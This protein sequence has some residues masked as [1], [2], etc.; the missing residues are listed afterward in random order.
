MTQVWTNWAGNQQARPQAAYVPRDV[1]ELRSVVERATASG[2]RVKAV[3]AGHSFTGV[4]VT[5]GVSVSLDHLTGIESVTRCDDGTSLVTVGAGTRL[6]DLGPALWERGLAMTNL[7]DIDAQSVAGALSTGTHGT[8][9]RFGGLASQVVGARIVLSDGDEVEATG[10][11]LEAARLGLGA[12]GVL[13][14]VTLRCEPAF[15]LRAV[16]APG[17]L[18][19][20]LE[21]FA[22]T[23]AALDHYEFYWFPHTDRVLTKANTRRAATEAPAPLG[24]VRGWVDDELLS[25]SAFEVLNRIGAVRPTVIP[26]MNRLAARALSAR[27]FTDRSYRVF[28]SSRR[29]RFR[30]MEFALAV[31]QVPDV[32]NEIRRWVD[33][34]DY[35]VAFPVEV[36]CAAADDVWLSTAYGRATGYVAVHQYHRREP[37]AYFDAVEKIATAAGGRPHWGKL[38][39]RAADDLRS[40]YEHFDNFVAVRDKVDPQG[41]FDNAYLRSVLGPR[42]L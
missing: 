14:A 5:D 22:A 24:R 15:L 6:H 13:T 3:G 33:R 32:L 10:D 28:A 19:E 30:E 38:H 18:G 34:S 39:T 36:R 11:L 37:G 31:E 12:L 20:T 35:R 7:G 23:T 21:R 29:V 41:T 2:H 1:D 25:N 26:A 9:A 40:T 4:A 27:T 8:G 16:E 42:L 17:R